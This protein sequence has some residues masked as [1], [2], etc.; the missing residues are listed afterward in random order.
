MR[1]IF[2]VFFIIFIFLFSSAVDGKYHAGLYDPNPANGTYSTNY[3]TNNSGAGLTTAIIANYNNFTVPPAIIPGTYSMEFDS[4]HY[5]GPSLE[6]NSGVYADVNANIFGRVI[7]GHEWVGQFESGGDY[8]IERSYLIFN[9]T[10]LP[11]EAVIDS[12]YISMVIYDDQSTVDFN[13]SLQRIRDPAPHNPMQPLDYFRNAFVGEYATKNTSGYTDED[14]FNFTLPGAAFA[15]IDETGDTIF[16]L[17]S[18]QDIDRSAPA[19]GTD[20]WIGFY[21]PGGVEPWKA[22]HLIINYTI[23]ASNWAHIVNLSWL[24]NSSGSWQQYA[25]EHITAN[26]TYSHLNTNM[27]DNSTR[28][29]WR[30]VSECNGVTLDNETYWFE[31]GP[32]CSGNVTIA[33]FSFTI[34]TSS[35]IFSI[36]LIIL[37]WTALLLSWLQWRQKFICVV[38]AVSSMVLFFAASVSLIYVTEGYAVYNSALDAVATGEMHLASYM[39]YSMIFLFLGIFAMVWVFIR[40]FDFIF[41]TLTGKGMIME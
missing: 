36:A 41:E 14:W 27:T 5:S 40:V 37:A 22:P 30:V 7:P 24:S 11:D 31:T 17:R 32:A 28:Y 25:F 35:T 21:G 8:Y 16:G 34:P 12:A 23:P 18:D 3:L 13:V 19:V 29:W 39:P 4:V 33:G 2:F 15:D 38:L 9:T 26:G 10:T 6:N 1:K 20:E